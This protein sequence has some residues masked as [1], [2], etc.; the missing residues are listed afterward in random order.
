MEGVKEEVGVVG[1]DWVRSGLRVKAVVPLVTGLGDEGVEAEAVREAEE[2]E[3]RVP[4]SRTPEEDVGKA[5]YV[6]PPGGER[7]GELVK[8]GLEEGVMEALSEPNALMEG[9]GLGDTE[10]EEVSLWV[11]PL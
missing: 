4:R 10:G 7:D 6:P 8:L 2:Q 11:A 1:G 9:L 5:E 3:E